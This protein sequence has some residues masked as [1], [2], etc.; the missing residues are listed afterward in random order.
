MA[1]LESDHGRLLVSF[2]FNGARCRE[3]LG[4]DDNRDNRRAAKRTINEIEW[5]LKAGQFDYASRFPQSRRLERFEIKSKPEGPRPASTPVQPAAEERPG[6]PRLGQFAQSWLEERRA[7]LTPA[8]AYDYDRL[9]KALL[10][11]SP[12][13]QKRIDEVNDGDI[14]LFMGELSKRKTR[15]GEPI[16]PRRINMIIARLRTIFSV[17]KRRKLV[18]EDPMLFVQNLREPKAEV[19]PF[20]LEEAERLIDG[21]TGQDRAIVT[22]LVFC[23]LRPNEALALRWQDVDFDRR[24]LKVRRAIHRFGGIGLPKT[25]SSERDVDML[26]PVIAELE[27]QRARTQLRGE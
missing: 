24:I 14:H 27:E 2:Q 21:A 17:A 5:E 8:T 16:G 12:L 9:I 1:R 22:V 19:D 23:G 13:A 10:L 4:L 18:D 3:Y 26:D 15:S 6:V 20:E 11:P 25:A 7:V